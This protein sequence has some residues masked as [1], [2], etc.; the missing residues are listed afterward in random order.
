MCLVLNLL[1]LAVITRKKVFQ[2]SDDL[3]NV[4]LY[5]SKRIPFHKQYCFIRNPSH[6]FCVCFTE[7]RA[8]SG[9]RA[10][11][12]TQKLCCSPSLLYHPLYVR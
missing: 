1:L 8:P 2:D 3:V 6:Q 9:P 7:L 10:L 4:L 5:L 12:A 11:H